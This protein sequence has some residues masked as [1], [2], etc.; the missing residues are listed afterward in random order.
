M[1]MAFVIRNFYIL[2]LALGR[3]FPRLFG[4]TKRDVEL[5]YPVKEKIFYSTLRESGY[6]HIQCTKPDTVGEC[7]G[8]STAG[9]GGWGAPILVSK[10]PTGEAYP[11]SGTLPAGALGP[12]H[13][14]LCRSNLVHSHPNPN[15]SIQ[16]IHYKY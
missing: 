10:A 15:D 6:M 7:W 12:L 9:S 4:F 13:A 3:H 1:N 16:L 8:L 11:P 2:T 5:L 14:F